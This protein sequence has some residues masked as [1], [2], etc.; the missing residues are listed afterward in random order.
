MTFSLT[1]K[2]REAMLLLSGKQTHTLLVGGSRS[3]KTFLA[4]RAIVVRALAA[5]GSRHAILRFRFNAC[6]QSIGMDTL[7]KVLKLCFGLTAKENSQLGYFELPNGSQIWLG[8]LDDKERTEKILGLEFCTIYLNESSQIP[9]SSVELVRTRLAQMVMT[10]LDGQ[11]PKPLRQLMLYDANPP[12]KGH[13]TYRYFLQKEDPTTKLPL[14]DPSDIAWM[15][16][17]PDDNADNLPPDYITKTLG[18]MSARQQKRFRYGEFADANPNALFRDEDIDKWR[19]IDGSLP[20]MQ[21]IVVAV[22]PSGSGDVDNADNDAIGIVVAGLGTDGNAY[23]LEDCTVKAGPAV[24]GN[25]ATSAYDRHQADVIVGEI[26]YGGAMVGHVIQTARPRTNYKVVTATRG[27]VVRAEPFSAL[28]ENGKIRHAGY[29][30]ELEDE[31]TAFSTNGYTGQNSPNRADALIW[32]LTELFPGIVSARKQREP[33]K[34]AK[35]SLVIGG[36][37]GA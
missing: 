20:D 31:L 12:N 1:A 2:Q 3:G 26:N 21:R 4:V 27:K 7:P 13:W 33:A 6:R 10:K 14:S 5:P 8:G 23:I 30:R 25:I 9:W 16:L 22:D 35:R 28:Y 37:M 17:N 29:F 32:A 34:E 15:R 11:D 19:H 36:W 18:G 24:W